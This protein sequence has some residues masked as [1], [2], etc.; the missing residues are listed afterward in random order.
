MQLL[1]ESI[2]IQEDT[3]TFTIINPAVVPLKSDDKGSIKI[4]VLYLV[5]GFFIAIFRYVFVVAKRYVKSLWE[6]V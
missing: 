5:L 2:K 4:I 1:S 6:E 3:P